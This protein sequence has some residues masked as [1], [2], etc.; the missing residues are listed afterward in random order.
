MIEAEKVTAARKELLKRLAYQFKDEGLFDEALTHPSFNR[1]APEQP[2]NQRLEFLGDRV[3]GLIIADSLFA[4]HPDVAEGVLS[5]RYADCVS[6]ET[7]AQIARSLK[8]GE[9]LSVQPNTNLG[10]VDKVLADALEAIIGAIWR[11]GGMVAVQPIIADIWKDVIAEA[12]GKA[13]DSKTLLQEYMLKHKMSLPVYD[14]IDR[15]GTDHAPEFFVR[16][17]AG[18]KVA[19]ASGSSKQQAEQNAATIMLEMLT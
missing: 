10:D 8:I 7:L 19:E 14:I 6:N 12:Q 17:I 3:L 1:I 11:D 18:D 13:K 5:R 15:K 2:D 9:A 16:L 4:K